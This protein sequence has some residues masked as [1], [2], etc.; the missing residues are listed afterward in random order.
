LAATSGHYLRTLTATSGHYLR[1][2]PQG[3][4]S[5]LRTIPQD[6]DSY[7]STLPQD[8]N[9]CL[10]TLPQD[11]TSGHSQL[12]QDNT[13]GHYLRT[14]T[15]S[16]GQYLRTLPQDTDSYLRTPTATSGHYLRTLPQDTDSHEQLY[17]TC[18][19]HLY[20]WW[21]PP[22]VCQ[23]PGP[24]GF[25][26]SP[27]NPGW[28]PQNPPVGFGLRT[29]WDPARFVAS[30]VIVGLVSGSVQAC[31]PGP[32]PGK[33]LPSH[34]QPLGPCL[35]SPDHDYVCYETLSQPLEIE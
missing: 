21:Y 8:T 13:S 2:L 17:S 34:P 15:A 10:R 31:H 3:T 6:T 33:P 5:Y 9:R 27:W 26:W 11:I 14:P 16:L 32:G 25:L 12:P 22:S 1:T 19:Y 28:K 35:P 18:R 20:P 30:C 7:L 23:F 29:C 24:L 4:D